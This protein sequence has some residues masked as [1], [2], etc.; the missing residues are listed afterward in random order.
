MDSDPHLRE[1]LTNH[2]LLWLHTLAAYRHGYLRYVISM[3]MCGR[4]S[5]LV[6][7]GTV[8]PWGGLLITRRAQQHHIT[9]PRAKGDHQRSCSTMHLLTL[10]WHV[11]AAV[12]DCCMAALHRVPSTRGSG[13]AC[14]RVA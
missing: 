3:H 1:C 13:A 9:L 11:Q 7:L 12:I 2:T 14:L 8:C 10:L 4:E 6:L 5:P